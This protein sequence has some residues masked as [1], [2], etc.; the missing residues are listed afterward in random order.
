MSH[1]AVVSPPFL[2]HL[3]PMLALSGTLRAR[4]HRVTCFGM[5]DVAPVAARHGIPF[6]ALGSKTH[7]PGVLAG[8]L[9]RM[10][11]PG[12]L[13]LF[14]IMGDM[15]AHTRMLCAELPSACRTGRVDGLVTD[16]LEPGGALVAAHLGLPYVTVA[17]ALSIR[18][19]P[20]QP[21]AFVG[22]RYD[23]TPRG[24]TRNRGGHRVSDLLLWPVTAGIRRE[25]QALGLDRSSLDSCLSP[26]ADLTQLVPELDYP[27][28]HHPQTVH[29]CGPLRGPEPQEDLAP[30]LGETGRPVVFASMGTLQG[31]RLGIFRMIAEVCAR[32]GLHLVVAHGGRLSEQDAATLP[33]HPTVRAFVPQRALLRHVALAVTNGG[34]NTVLDAAAAGVPT[35]VIPIAFEQGAI[36]A[37]VE[38][39]GVGQVLP[40][41][42]LNQHRL[43]TAMQFLL[44]DPGVRRRAGEVACAIARA[45]GSEHAASL[46]E[47]ALRTGHP[48]SARPVADPL[49]ATA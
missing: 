26:F 31:G 3:N 27:R 6:V 1:I 18:R 4:G 22:W 20:L 12:G 43:E 23:P 35:L 30:L 32:L 2:G 47:A 15:T 42:R 39:A 9:A 28:R 38:H 17:N 46:V 11:A 33:G 40:R 37:R 16:Q 44:S 21:P 7:P 5:A 10:A 8:V 45:G 13:G 19:D 34:L 48:A 25:A 14:R 41:R 49:R 29:A 24:V 36:G